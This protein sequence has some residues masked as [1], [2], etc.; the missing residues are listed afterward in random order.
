MKYSVNFTCKNNQPDDGIKSRENGKADSGVT[1]TKREQEVLEMVTE[2]LTTQEI[3]KK[4]F[5]S[6]DT[7]ETHRRN[8]IQKFGARNTVDAVVKAMRMGMIK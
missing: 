2:G 1:L 7:V 6:F 8:I 3:A 4:I 5:V